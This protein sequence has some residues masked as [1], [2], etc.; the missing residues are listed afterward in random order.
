M[1]PGC[2]AGPDGYRGPVTSAA[3]APDW[4]GKRLGLPAEGPRSIGRLGRRLVAI[5]IDWGAAL[6]ISFAFFRTSQGTD[7]FVNLAVFAVLQI[8]FLELVGATPGHLICRMRLVPVTGGR[9]V[10]WRPIWRTLLLCIVIP[11]VIWDR[12]QRG[13]HD[14]A[15]GTMLVRI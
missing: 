7:A 3:S 2:Y 9:L 6:L 12:D 1:F 10:W 11:A 4:P 5:L 8:A 13:V 14:R 15:A